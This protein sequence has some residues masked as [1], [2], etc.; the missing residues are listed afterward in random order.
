MGRFVVHLLRRGEKSKM[1]R[2]SLN[3]CVLRSVNSE[4]AFL[5]PQ[6]CKGVLLRS[7]NSES[8]FLDP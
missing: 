2:W 7:V 4:S 1:P 6:T 8:A 3:L 5:D